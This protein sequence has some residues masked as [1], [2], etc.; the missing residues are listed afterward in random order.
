MI[1]KDYQDRLDHWLKER[2]VEHAHCP[3]DCSHPQP[4]F[5]GDKLICGHCYH[6]FNTITE[7]MPCVPSV[8]A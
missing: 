5:L 4:F 3:A 7:M 6:R 8:C 2:G 1:Y